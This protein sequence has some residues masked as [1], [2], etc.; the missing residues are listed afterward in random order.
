MA[1]SATRPVRHGILLALM[2]ATW[3]LACSPWPA[4][5][6][7]T[8]VTADVAVNTT[9]Q[10]ADSP[11]VVSGDI[12]V[13]NNAK[14]TIEPGVTVQFE[15]LS[16]LTIE[17]GALS[18]QGN[19][20]A[21][22]VFTSIHDDGQGAPAPGD[23]GALAF[24]PDT[25]DTGTIL[26]WV[27]V[28]Y[29]QGI[30][31]EGASPT[32]NDLRIEHSAGPAVTLDLTSSPKGR[33]LE[34]SDNRLNGILVPA[35]VIDTDIQWSLRGIPYVLEEGKVRIGHL[36]FELLPFELELYVDDPGALEV[37]IPEP[38]PV[39]GLTVNINSIPV[40][41]LN[42][43]ATVV[44]EEGQQT[45]GIDLQAPSYPTTVTV[46]AHAAGYDVAESIVRVVARPVLGLSPAANLSIPNPAEVELSISD[47]APA[48]GLTIPLDATPAGIIDIPA[49]VTIPAGSS[50][51]R[52]AAQG[53]AYGTA[54]LAAARTPYI[55]ATTKLTVQPVYV[56]IEPGNALL[57]PGLSRELTARITKPAPQG[58]TTVLLSASNT[59]RVNV[60]ASVQIPEDETTALVEITG[61]SAGGTQIF[62][63]ALGYEPGSSL[64]E[65]KDVQIYAADPVLVPLGQAVPIRVHVSPTTGMSFT[66]HVAVAE[67]S[68]VSASL[69]DLNFAGYQSS[70]TALALT[71]N[72]EG[73][74]ELQFTSPGLHPTTV[75]V[76]VGEPY[77]EFDENT[78]VVGHQLA[79]TV[80]VRRRI[81]VHGYRPPT[82]LT[83][84][85]AST[86]ATKLGVP[87]EITIPAD[88]D[89]AS[90]KLSGLGLTQQ[91]IEI[92]AVAEGYRSPQ[93]PLMARV[94]T[95]SLV[96][97]DLEGVRE[98]DD[99]RD[100]FAL[101]WLVPG[102]GNSYQT[103][104]S[105][106][107][108]SL[109]VT[110][111][112]PS[113]VVSGLEDGEGSPITEALI[114][115]GSNSSNWNSFVGSPTEVGTYKLEASLA[116]AGQW[117]SQEQRVVRGWLEFTGNIWGENKFVLGHGLQDTLRFELSSNRGD[118]TAE[119]PV[120][121]TLSNPAQDKIHVPENVVIPV[122]ETSVE[123]LAQGLALTNDTV[124][125][126]VAASGY[127][128][129]RSNSGG[130]GGSAH[131]SSNSTSYP[132]DGIYADVITPRLIVDDLDGSR[133]PGDVED[134]FH[135]R[136]DV[137]LPGQTG[138][139][140][141]QPHG[142]PVGQTAI[143]D[144]LIDL[145]VLGWPVGIIEAIH[146]RYGVATGQIRIA[147][148]ENDSYASFDQENHSVTTPTTTGG[149]RI[150]ASLSNVGS[151]VSGRQ[152]VGNPALDFSP[153]EIV[154]GLGLEPRNA[155][156][157]D[158]SNWRPD[159][160]EPD[161][162]EPRIFLSCIS[163]DV[164]TVPEYVE[165]SDSYFQINAV[166]LG[167]T[168]V[169]PESDGFLGTG[170]LR[171][172]VVKPNLDLSFN[173]EFF[174]GST[175][176][177]DLGL[178]LQSAEAWSWRNAAVPITVHLTSSDPSVVTV[179]E[180]VT[181]EPQQNHA[182][183]H[184]EAIGVGTARITVSGDNVITAS[185][186]ITV[187]P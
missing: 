61:I 177:A 151:W 147:A 164:C 169:L 139:G 110:D 68:V 83:V 165:L 100:N 18:A 10:L 109:A 60:P 175:Y 28:R 15:E 160:G 106:Q 173:D 166:G 117:L 107:T 37:S 21:P 133:E 172:E 77:L 129:R 36:D 4:A 66:V 156:V 103:A 34:A 63:T 75:A 108:I 85:L 48:G 121:I 148:G 146:D 70:S 42:L 128:L 101:R 97:E 73:S 11:Y 17:H 67:P 131:R 24:Q 144:Q 157:Y 25:Q 3:M 5:Q 44:I 134:D 26:S 167:A 171:V 181:I 136:W 161:P 182:E 86:D 9:W 113:G 98:I 184:L 93:N 6:A 29:G 130:G 72:A 114:P 123:S 158:Y 32:F 111:A 88:W 39:G 53:L 22:I 143:A 19:S 119:G 138:G 65:I 118:A 49:E 55:P 154:L 186:T 116:G 89:S 122:G 92:T 87:P 170:Q 80:S 71:G 142:S 1:G 58:G 56:K 163:E 150:E 115:A 13:I 54:T 90:F 174:V 69:S 40:G 179:Q 120:T 126:A 162:P 91:P 41:S 137:P 104:L 47:V 14:L 7:A 35:G 27:E 46:G 38:A 95:P 81:G 180:Q 153:N 112:L 185:Q 102:S 59:T 51:T 57:A 127:A 82:S 45:A 124:R 140:G 96:F 176:S 94:V 12:A 76:E 33:G 168:Y 62:G 2:L 159:E 20:T 152:I 155:Q 187:Q 30:V 145:S 43:P 23:W 74:S 149:Y 125:I 178:Y 183:I 78:A 16:S 31:V 50:S 8:I 135:V 84:Q 79:K 52:F 132:D 64:V 99:P 141:L 105:D